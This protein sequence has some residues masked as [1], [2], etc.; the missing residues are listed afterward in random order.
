M[1]INL[2]IFTSKQIAI[3]YPRTLL[4]KFYILFKKRRL[5]LCESID[6]WRISYGSLNQLR[7]IVQNYYILTILFKIKNNCI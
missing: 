5:N 4:E 1:W 2:V 6:V 3:E 7:I